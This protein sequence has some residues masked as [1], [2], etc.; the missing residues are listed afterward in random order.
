MLHQILPGGGAVARGSVFRALN[1]SSPSIIAV[2]VFILLKGCV[3]RIG[4]Y[5]VCAYIAS[6]QSGS[7]MHTCLNNLLIFICPSSVLV[8]A[9]S[10]AC[11][12][13]MVI[14]YNVCMI[15]TTFT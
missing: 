2:G 7:P 12:Y 11:I 5:V 1:I 10:I 13:Y 15:Y 6:I 9:F 4:R 14:S 3:V 8:K